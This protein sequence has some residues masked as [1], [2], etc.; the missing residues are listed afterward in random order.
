MFLLR[1]LRP[2]F[3]FEPWICVSLRNV[4][5]VFSILLTQ[6]HISYGSLLCVVALV[7]LLFAFIS[8]QVILCKQISYSRGSARICSLIHSLPKG[9]VALW[10][11]C[12]ELPKRTVETRSG[13]RLQLPCS[14][15]KK[16]ICSDNPGVFFH[17]CPGLWS[18]RDQTFLSLCPYFPLLTKGTFSPK[19][20][21]Q[22][23]GNKRKSSGR[24]ENDTDKAQGGPG[25]HA[26]VSKNEARAQASPLPL[27]K[28]CQYDG[29]P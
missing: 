9:T 22:P 7:R 6:K 20:S 5:K 11:I 3:F 26:R 23:P 27:L 4:I 14:F 16:A 2:W 1:F 17:T 12:E 21:P 25:R 29:V 13:A 24:G 15:R 10:I 18:C 8:D 28:S 19:H